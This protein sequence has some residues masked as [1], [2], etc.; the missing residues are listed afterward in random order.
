MKGDPKMNTGIFLSVKDLMI[1][2][3]IDS[4]DAAR[5]EHAYIRLAL[6]K[7]KMRPIQNKRI[8]KRKLT[9]SEYCKY[10]GLEFVE[11]WRFLR[12]KASHPDVNGEAENTGEMRSKPENLETPQI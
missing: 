3:G 11:I 4:Y 1:L 7:N 5:K 6:C 8:A 9:I 2:A 10:M 12:G